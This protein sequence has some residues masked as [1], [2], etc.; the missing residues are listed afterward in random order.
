MV[1]FEAAMTGCEV[2]RIPCKMTMEGCEMTMLLRILSSPFRR[3]V[4]GIIIVL[5]LWLSTFGHFDV[6]S[7][8]LSPF[9]S[10]LVSVMA[11]TIRI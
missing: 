3:L 5:T 1:Q 11:A 4:L 7:F 2:M 8:W 10:G 6:L 9:I